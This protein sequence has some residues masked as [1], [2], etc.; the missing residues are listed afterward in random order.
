MDLTWPTGP[1]SSLPDPPTRPR[2][3]E[4]EGRGGHPAVLRPGGPPR[5]PLGILRRSIR[6][7]SRAGLQARRPQDVA[8]V[9]GLQGA[10]TALEAVG[11]DPYRESE[12]APVDRFPEWAMCNRTPCP[13]DSGPWSLGD[14]AG[15]SYVARMQ[16]HM[17]VQL[18]DDEGIGGPIVG[19]DH[20]RV[21]VYP[22]DRV[23]ECPGCLTRLSVYNHGSLCAAHDRLGSARCDHV[24]RRASRRAGRSSRCRAT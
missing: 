11:A 9:R 14:S 1:S 13:C 3:A 15:P 16:T 12:P 6:P 19:A 24:A 7:S 10:L 5:R 4:G 22:R 18:R 8:V 2:P 17:P 21:K 20:H 23:C